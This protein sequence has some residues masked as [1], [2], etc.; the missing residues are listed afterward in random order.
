MTN[1]VSPDAEAIFDH[2]ADVAAEVE[3]PV[4][5]MIVFGSTVRGDRDSESDTD[6]IVV[7]DAFDPDTPAYERAPEFLKAW[8]HEY[9]PVDFLCL[10]PD[11]YAEKQENPASALSDAADEGVSIDLPDPDAS[12]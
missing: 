5:E 9:G 8:D 6:V 12:E 11:E 2:L 3:T 1:S 7:S 10:T 4:D